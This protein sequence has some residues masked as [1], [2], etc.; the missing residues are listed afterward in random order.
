MNTGP[1]AHSTDAAA[2][3]A[4]AAAS[5]PSAGRTRLNA[6]KANKQRKRNGMADAHR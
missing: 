3:S 1:H 6:S 4:Q 2:P 5:I